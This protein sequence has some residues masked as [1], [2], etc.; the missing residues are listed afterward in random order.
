MSR[1]RQQRQI[2][3]RLMKNARGVFKPVTVDACAFPSIKRAYA[4]NWYV[5]TIH[6]KKMWDQEFEVAM[7]QK[8]DDTPIENHWSELQHIK[9]QIF[10][11][12]ATAIEF[13]PPSSTLVD[14]ANVY[15]LWHLEHAHEYK[16]EP[17]DRLKEA[18]VIVEHTARCSCNCQW[19]ATDVEQNRHVQSCMVG[20]AQ[21]I[22]GQVVSEKPLYEM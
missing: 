18:M 1:T 22:L 20:K 10:G 2:A 6:I 16:R 14:H 7:V 17:M 5:V 19:S 4:N 12:E 11:L 8:H 3:K 15:W 9:N 21:L 13:Y